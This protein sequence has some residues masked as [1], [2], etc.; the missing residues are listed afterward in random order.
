[1]K[2][3]SYLGSV[4][5][6]NSNTQKVDLLLKYANGV[7]RAGDEGLVV[8]G[9]NLIDCDVAVIQGW[10]YKQKHTPHL[11]LRD[12]II[13]HQ[14][15]KNKYTCVADANLF[16]Y[17]DKSNRY[18]YLRYSFNGVFPSTG[19][20]CDQEVDPKRWQKISSDTGITL[21]NVKLGNNIVLCVQRNG[22]WSMGEQN[23]VEWIRKTVYKLR[24]YTDR[25][26]V[27]RPHPGDKTVHT[28]LNDMRIREL[29]AN[30]NVVISN[31]GTPLDSDLKNC[32]A[33]VNHN[34]SSI[35]GPIIKGYHSFITDSTNS[36]C[37]EVSNNDLSKIES[38]EIF[39]RQKW[40]E[41]ISMFHWK[42][43][44]LDSGE[45]WSHMRNYC[46]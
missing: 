43:K 19:I 26:I 30:H 24:K 27:V 32:Y 37:S 10:V 35:V 41:R 6:K 1:M 16:L 28:Y 4:P 7:Q 42:F 18:G 44:E 8:Q 5:A 21:E 34:S 3:V 12:N 38:P 22:G 31:P 20:Y 9:N 14:K 13:N 17:A 2:V 33:V 29:V 39:D 23:L 25:K 40:L 15:L 11:K 36:Q 45:C 46:Q